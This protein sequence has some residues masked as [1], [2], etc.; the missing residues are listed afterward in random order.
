MSTDRPDNDGL[1]QGYHV[2]RAGDQTVARGRVD[3]EVLVESGD[4]SVVSNNTAV[5]GAY[6]EPGTTPFRETLK[7]AG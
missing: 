7:M 3:G 1:I 6:P 4:A 2:Y 5:A